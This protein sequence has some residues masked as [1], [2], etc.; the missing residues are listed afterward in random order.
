MKMNSR[1]TVVSLILS[2]FLLHGSVEGQTQLGDILYLKNGS[3]IKGTILEFIPD[4]TVKIQTSDGSIF[5]FQVS[6]VEK[7]TKESSPLPSENLIRQKDI[8]EQSSPWKTKAIFGFHG[9]AGIP[10]GDFASTTGSSAGG[11]KIGFSGGMDFR[12][13]FSDYVNWSASLNVSLSS[14]DEQALRAT[15]GAPTSLSAG[16]WTTIWALTGLG[17]RETVAPQIKFFSNGEIG[18]LIGSSPEYS[19]SGYVGSQFISISQKSSTAISFA[20]SVRAGLEISNFLLGV[21]YFAGKP[22]YDVTATGGGLSSSGSFEQST[23]IIQVYT[24][25]VF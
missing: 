17:F 19:V 23:S 10:V 11:A 14:L 2:V 4:K 25:I 3:I 8:V 22:K 13:A 9:G 1:I 5:V 20:Y 15:F 16:S 18:A 6:E 7:I 24:G 21:G 12:L